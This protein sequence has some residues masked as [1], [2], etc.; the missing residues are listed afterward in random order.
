MTFYLDFSR[1][2]AHNFV[3]KLVFIVG[4]VEFNHSK[5]C[6]R[7]NFAVV[8]WD[9]M[10]LTHHHLS[11]GCYKPPGRSTNHN[12]KPHE[13]LKL[14]SKLWT[15]SGN[16]RI[17]MA[18]VASFRT[19]CFSCGF[20]SSDIATGDRQFSE[21]CQDPSFMFSEEKQ[22]TV[23]LILQGIVDKLL[24]EKCIWMAAKEIALNV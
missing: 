23:R 13:H 11:S 17:S 15:E 12:T 18:F 1:F 3:G 14:L 20:I 2:N 7:Q 9:S 22:L 16:L 4:S 6:S 8:C 19:M 21:D 10:R 5:P 24:Q